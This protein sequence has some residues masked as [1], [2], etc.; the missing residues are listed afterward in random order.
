MKKHLW[1]WILITCFLVLAVLSFDDESY[2]LNE[3]KYGNP[4]GRDYGGRVG[5][6][7]FLMMH[8]AGVDETLKRRD[9]LGWVR[10]MN[11]IRARAE[12]IALKEIIYT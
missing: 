8:R 1:L 4:Y 11:N 10:R 6:G 7:K 5:D 3:E 2:T 12:E 9:Q